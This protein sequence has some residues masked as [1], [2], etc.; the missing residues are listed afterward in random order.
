MAVTA[1]WFVNGFFSLMNKEADL[2]SDT[3]KCALFTSA[4]APDSIADQYYDGSHGMTQVSAANGYSTGGATVSSPTITQTTKTITNDSITFDCADPSWTVTSTGFTYRY[5]VFY[6]DT[7][8]SNKPLIAY[9]DFGADV[10]AVAGTHTIVLD[11]AG[12]ARVTPA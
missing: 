5:A 11:S 2:N 12:V 4:H 9:V 6:D 1:K 8:A 7:P 3:I 10:T